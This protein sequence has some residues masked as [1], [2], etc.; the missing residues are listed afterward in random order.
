[1]SIIQLIEMVILKSEK[2]SHGRIIKY[3]YLY[4]ENLESRISIVTEEVAEN[5]KYTY[6]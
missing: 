1:M 2:I 6:I 4:L 3:A 5:L